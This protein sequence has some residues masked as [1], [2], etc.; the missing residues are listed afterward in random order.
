MSFKLK[1]SFLVI[2]G[3][4]FCCGAQAENLNSEKA[5]PHKAEPAGSTGKQV[6]TA[7]PAAN[8]TAAA[9]QKQTKPQ[10]PAKQ[11]AAAKPNAK[12]TPFSKFKKECYAGVPEVDQSEF[13]SRTTPV[14]I[15][16]DEAN[17]ADENNFSFNGNVKITQGNRTMDA[18]Y[19]QFNRTSQK[20]NAYGNINYRDGYISI[21]DASEVE[22]SIR[23]KTL[24]VTDPKYQLHGSPARGEA[25]KADYNQ[26]EKSYHL[27][28][29]TF[30]TCQENAETW[31]LEATT[32][33]IDEDE[34]FGEAWNASLWLYRIPI[35]YLPYINFPIRNERKTGFLYPEIGYSGNDGFKMTAP[36]YWN[37]APNYDYT[38]TPT[39]MGHRGLHLSN[40]FRYM[41]S[42]KHTGDIIY[43]YTAHDKLAEKEDGIDSSRWYKHWSHRSSFLNG[44]LSLF[45]N[46]N[47]V[48]EKDYNYFNDYTKQ[49][50]STDKVVQ[51]LGMVYSPFNFTT[52]SVKAENYQ[53]LIDTSLKPFEVLPQITVKNFTPLPGMS[54]YNTFEFANFSHSSENKQNGNFEGKRYHLQSKLQLPL[55]QQ[56][57]FQLDSNLRMMFTH[58]DQT[59]LGDQ[60]LSYY[61]RRGFTNIASS[62]NRFIPTFQIQAR[63][64]MDNDFSLFG[65]N[66]SQ[67][68]EPIIQYYY[69]PYRNQDDIGLYD[70][71]NIVQDYFFIFDD[72]KYA[73]IDRITDDNR[74]ST[75]F[76]SR[77]SDENGIER[78]IFSLGMAYYLREGKVKL[79]PKYNEPNR[80]RSFLNASLDLKPFNN[81]LYNGSLIYNTEDRYLDRASS[82]LEYSSDDWVAQLNYRYTRNG[83][84]TMF[85]N[86]IID[87]RQLGLLTKFS[88]SDRLSMVLGYY[89]DLEQK[90]AIDKVI[91]LRYEDCC[92]R[93]SA[94]A[95][96]VYEP[97]NRR[98]I[99]DLDTKFG[100]QFEMKGLATLG[101]KDISDTMDTRLLPYSRPFNLSEN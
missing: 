20:F 87:M 57:F 91:K 40:E 29:A 67:S 41:I 47:K 65:H 83:N 94:Y 4:C 33:N 22:S 73:G 8:G 85:G 46:Y 51:S 89:Q 37:I 63:L 98:K 64:I 10:S 54:L 34:V 80:R 66:F 55:I 13:D 39:W 53:M 32:V 86:E 19:T 48:R 49:S 96:Q 5:V 61:T 101:A 43:E 88:F 77:I 35:F 82:V 99:A 97:D 42:P 92:W 11:P 69:A 56:P 7:G 6:Q 70:T 52:V 84:M 24:S 93:F 76:V 16:S 23:N 78:A 2:A 1:L 62:V 3:A 74:L 44:K 18:D 21:R 38:L 50:G 75:G 17:T 72:N 60:L 95:E 14:D 25:S 26:L 45:A 12:R 27:E 90:R 36:F 71:T 79:Y 15:L 68:L 100:I 59:V 9:D 28:K 30:T 31:H 58:Y 81:V